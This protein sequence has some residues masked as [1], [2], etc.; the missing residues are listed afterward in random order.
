MIFGSY[1]KLFSKQA[2]RRPS[3]TVPAIEQ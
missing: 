1:L 2:F 3:S